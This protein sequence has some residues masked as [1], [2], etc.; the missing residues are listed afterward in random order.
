MAS[1]EAGYKDPPVLRRLVGQ[2]HIPPGLSSTDT[3]LSDPL[4]RI[5]LDSERGKIRTG[6]QASFQFRRLPVRPERAGSDPPQSV[7]RPYS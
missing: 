5:G 4:L 3:N 7:G 2:G 6:T 1:N